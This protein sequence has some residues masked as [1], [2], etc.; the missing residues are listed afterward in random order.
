[1]SKATVIR[2][3]I[4]GRPITENRENLLADRFH[5][6][7]SLRGRFWSFRSGPY[8]QRYDI[9]VKCMDKIFA[10]CQKQ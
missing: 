10:E 1:M 4:C 3:D 9:C 8:W 7:V 2:C 6:K 5:V